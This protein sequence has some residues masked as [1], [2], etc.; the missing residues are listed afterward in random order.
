M[1]DTAGAIER[2]SELSNGARVGEYPSFAD[3]R[4]VVAACAQGGVLSE[5]E[6]LRAIVKDLA[7]SKPVAYN[8]GWG[9]ECLICWSLTEDEP[10]EP[11]CA[12]LLAVKEGASHA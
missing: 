10:H 9:P 2:V 3:L 1:S 6:R 11:D 5:L 8:D 12:W 7:S 4:L